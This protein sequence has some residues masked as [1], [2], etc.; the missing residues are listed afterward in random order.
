MVQATKG[1]RE[2]FQKFYD[3]VGDTG[4]TLSIGNGWDMTVEVHD[5]D[6]G[7]KYFATGLF[8]VLNGDVAFDPIFHMNGRIVNGKI[9][10][11]DITSYECTLPYVMLYIDSRD[12]AHMAGKKGRDPIGLC[13][14]FSDFIEEMDITFLDDESEV[15][16]V[17]KKYDCQ[18]D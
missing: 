6:G 4:G 2:I 18:G 15:E 11:L 16:P 3:V 14:R 1:S 12:I 8:T 13:K 9:T 5:I 7:H 17:I 10:S